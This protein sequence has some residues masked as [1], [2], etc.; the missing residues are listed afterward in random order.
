MWCILASLWGDEFD[1]EETNVKDIVKKAKNPKNKG[2]LVATAIKSKSLS[3]R[4]KLAIIK[5]EVFRVLGSYKDNIGVIK[6]KNDLHEYISKAV[7]NGIISVD[8]ETNNSLDPWDCKIAGACLY[9]PGEKQV[10]IPINHINIDTQERLSWQITEQELKEELDRLD[11]TKII[12]HNAKFDYEVIYCTCNCKLR[13]DWDTMI[14]AKILNENEK[15]SLKEQ[16]ILHVDDSVERYSI[17][18]LFD[19]M[20]YLLVDPDVFAYYAATDAYMTYRLYQ[21]QKEQ[22][23]LEDNKKLFN[24]FMT[25][26]M[27][28]VEVVASMEMRGVALDLDYAKR[29]KVKYDKRL[30]E[31]SNIV[32]S[33]LSKLSDTISKWRLSAEANQKSAKGKSKAEQ[34][35]NPINIDSNIQLAIILYD[36][37]KITPPDKRSPRAVS[38]K[39]LSKIDIPLTKA[40][41]AKRKEQKLINTYIDAMPAQ[42][43]KSDGRLHGRY[44]QY[45]AETGRFSS[46]SPNLQN[47]PSKNKEIRLMFTAGEG[48]VLVGSDFSLQKVG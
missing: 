34:L 48:N 31:A 5:D 47:L 41:L 8:T 3:L 12:F 27:P 6:T 18:K 36:I 22:F 17:N 7:A 21:Y 1:V 38:E 23:D 39:E 30:N 13:I 16:Y 33:E 37:L 28:I 35:T 10:Y 42:V 24:L 9:T 4:E 43:S 26:E 40:I 11:N 25:V 44:N 29:L 20:S 15:A 32:D 45:G 19:K 14:A 46:D 2:G